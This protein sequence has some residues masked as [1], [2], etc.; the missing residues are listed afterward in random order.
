MRLIVRA[1]PLALALSFATSSAI[2]QVGAAA[3]TK[4]AVVDSRVI[5]Q[6][7]PGRADAEASFEKEVAAYRVSVQKNRDSLA[8]LEAN[9]RKVEATLSPAVRE[10]RQK[11]LEK[12]GADLQEKARTMEQQMQQ[13]Q[14]ELLQPI[15]DQVRKI[16]DDIRAENGYA[17]IFDIGAQ[18]NPLVAFENNLDIT[19]RVVTRLKAAPP[20][21]AAKPSTAAPSGAPLSSPAGVTRPK[22]PT[23]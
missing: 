5:M 9:Y 21:V 2:A 22:P 3:P 10:T 17:V 23:R 1:A 11:D 6:Q 19:E 4:V 7:A 8:A 18:G 16:L 13:K 15:M 20:P 12:K 14:Y